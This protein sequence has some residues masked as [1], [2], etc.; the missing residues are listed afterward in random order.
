[1]HPFLP[2]LQANKILLFYKSFAIYKLI[3]QPARQFFFHV[4]MNVQ[5]YF[6]ILFEA[7]VGNMIPF[8]NCPKGQNNLSSKVFYHSSLQHYL[9]V[10]K[11]CQLEEGISSP[12]VTF[13]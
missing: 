11:K 1:M 5:K 7:S 6:C 4:C 3:L 8:F 9:Y 12:A 2:S 13:V 10:N